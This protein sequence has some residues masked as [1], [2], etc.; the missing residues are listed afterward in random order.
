MTQFTH[1]NRTYLFVE[2]PEGA[3]SF[4]V[5]E[6]GIEYT[7]Q[8]VMTFMPLCITIPQGDWKIFGVVKD[9]MEEQWSSILPKIETQGNLVGKTVYHHLDNRFKK[10]GHFYTSSALEAGHSLIRSKGLHV[11]NPYPTPT[12]LEIQQASWADSPITDNSR[13]VWK[14]QEAKKL[15]IGH[16]LLL[17]KDDK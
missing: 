14:W 9:L 11:E 12:T 7:I 1:G 5:C 2:V 3:T 15:T 4:Y 8:G 16:T 13:D 17:T 6:H 10:Q